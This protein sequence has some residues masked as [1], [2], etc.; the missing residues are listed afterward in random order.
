MEMVKKVSEEFSGMRLDKVSSMIFEDYSRSQLKKWIIEGRILLNNE[1]ASPR[2][3]S[4]YKWWNWNNPI[5][6]K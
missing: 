5:Y 2:E 4:F 1:L 3:T 6:G